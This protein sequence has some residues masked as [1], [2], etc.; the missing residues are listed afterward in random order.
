VVLY[1][2]DLHSIKNHLISL[3]ARMSADISSFQGGRRFQFLNPS[4]NELAIWSEQPQKKAQH[5]C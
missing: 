5:L 4:G 2:N 1:C 3:N